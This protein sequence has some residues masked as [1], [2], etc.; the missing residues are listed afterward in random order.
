M[1]NSELAHALRAHEE[2]AR[3]VRSEALAV[4]EAF[5][6]VDPGLAAEIVHLFSD[7]EVAAAWVTSDLDD[8]EGSPAYLVAEGRAAEVLARLRKAAH[9]LPG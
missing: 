2:A 6:R 7:I 1:N 9:G 8:S 3:N 4:W 5:S